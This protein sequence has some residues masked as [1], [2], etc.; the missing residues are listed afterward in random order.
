MLKREEKAIHF[1]N[2]V[3]E[4][5]PLKLLSCEVDR[6]RKRHNAFGGKF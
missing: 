6:S 5:H 4:I 1:K 2:V 3:S